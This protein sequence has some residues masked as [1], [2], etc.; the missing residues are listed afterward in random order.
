MAS[1]YH[2]EDRNI[3]GGS[4]ADAKALIRSKYHKQ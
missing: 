4:L 2:T 3:S 1:K